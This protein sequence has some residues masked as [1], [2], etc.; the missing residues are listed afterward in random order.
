MVLYVPVLHKGYVQIFSDYADK[1]DALFVI[2]ENFID[3]F[4]FI[5]KEIRAINPDLSVKLIESM[6]LFKEVKILNKSS[7]GLISGQDRIIT[8]DESISRNLIIKYFP[9]NDVTFLPVFLRWDEGNVFSTKPVS[10]DL[11]SSSQFDREVMKKVNNEADKSSDWWRHVGA[12][13]VKNNEI[14]VLSHNQHLPSEHTPYINGDPRDFIEAGKMSEFCG[15]IHAERDII[16]IA[17]KRGIKTEGADIYVSVFPCPACAKL[18]ARAG[19]SRCFFGSGHAS[20][21]GEKNLKDDKVQIIL[22]K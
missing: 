21:D 19:F 11:E 18:V 20:L 6:N 4:K 13:I 17:A 9:K 16:A 22:V 10:Y 1:V 3:E 7:L 8:A 14:I 12:A 2:G 5:H 15:S